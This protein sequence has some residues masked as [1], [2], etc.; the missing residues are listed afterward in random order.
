MAVMR[1]MAAWCL[2]R[3]MHLSVRW[4]PSE[5]NPADAPARLFRLQSKSV[6]P[7]ED[8]VGGPLPRNSTSR[9]FAQTLG[10]AVASFGPK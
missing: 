2:S 9:D 10:G 4:I 8:D 7:K 5:R 6:A 1:R 3:N